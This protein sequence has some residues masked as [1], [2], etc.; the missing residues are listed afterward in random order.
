METII[1]VF[2]LVIDSF[3]ASIAYGAD[4]IKIPNTYIIVM[5]IISAGILA[6]SLLL[7]NYIEDIL[8]S[9]LPKFI[10]FSIFTILGIYK[11]F[12]GVFKKFM[13]KYTNTTK[14]LTFKLFDFKFALEVYLD[15]K[16][17][18]YDRSKNISL[19]ES[20]YLAIALS[21]DSLAVGFGASFINVN[22]L[23]MIMTCFIFGIA[24]I[25]IGSYIGKNMISSSN[26]NLSW[27]SGICLLVIAFLKL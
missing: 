2:S 13:N 18:D 19:K 8:P 16:K 22:S 3:V 26:N 4:K 1:L 11:L 9:Y 10:S 14:P 21:I 7:G 17:A 23:F 25:K 12:E 15:E 6:L 20:I 5:N 24:S 27:V